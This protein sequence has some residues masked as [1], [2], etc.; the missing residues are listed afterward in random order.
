MA[1]HSRRTLELERSAAPPPA[2]VDDDVKPERR[3]RSTSVAVP[4]T[5]SPLLSNWKGSKRTLDDRKASLKPPKLEDEV[6]DRKERKKRRREVRL[7]R[8]LP[9]R[10]V[11]ASDRP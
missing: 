2:D 6:L 5:I 11:G 9:G 1:K 4:A 3:P 10:E 8:N 7:R